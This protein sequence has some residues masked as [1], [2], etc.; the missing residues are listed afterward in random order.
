LKA[1]RTLE[2]VAFGLLHQ[3]ISVVG[4]PVVSAICFYELKPILSAFTSHSLLDRDALLTLPFF[5]FQSLTALSTGITL[6]L[7]SRTFGRSWTARIVWVLPFCGLLILVLAWKS[8]RSVVGESWWQH[9][10]SSDSF[11]ARKEQLVTT[12]PFFCSVAYAVGNYLGVACLKTFGDSV[13][14]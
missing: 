9:F 13:K 14:R 7:K 1:S 11:Y 2:T 12:L 10:F 6:A 3:A 4:I 5:P 8:S